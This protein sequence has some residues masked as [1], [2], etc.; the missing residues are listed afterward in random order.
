[1]SCATTFR[2]FSKRAMTEKRLG[3]TGLDKPAAWPIKDSNSNR[4]FP[5][6]NTTQHSGC[7]LGI[8]H[9]THLWDIKLKHRGAGVLNTSMSLAWTCSEHQTPEDTVDNVI[10]SHQFL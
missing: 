7:T 8:L 2:N 10:K 6:C 1:M 4:V 3:N 9:Q 5:Q